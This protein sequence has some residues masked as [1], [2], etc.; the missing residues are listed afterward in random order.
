MYIN[1]PD[2]EAELEVMNFLNERTRH[3]RIGKVRLKTGVKWADQGIPDMIR[4]RLNAPSWPH[5]G[6]PLPT[7]QYM[8]KCGCKVGDVC[9]SVACP[10][11]AVVYC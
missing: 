4:R 8:D 6:R 10:H 3:C 7:P 5:D 1:Y 2:H 9:M 11:R